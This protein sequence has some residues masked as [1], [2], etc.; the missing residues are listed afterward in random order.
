MAI[1]S[2]VVDAIAIEV[3]QRLLEST[4]GDINAKSLLLA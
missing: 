1:T 3:K 2:D 4:P